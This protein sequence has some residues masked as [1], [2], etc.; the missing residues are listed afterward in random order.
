[1]TQATA[2][3]FAAIEQNFSG[4][5]QCYVLKKVIRSY[6]VEVRLSENV[7]GELL[8]QAV[9]KTLSRLP[10]YRQTIVRQKGIYYYAE[11]DLPFKV[12]DHDGPRPVGGKEANYHM[13][14]VVYHD[15]WLYFSMWHALCDGLGLNRFIE[16]VL[17]H[18]L[19]AKDG[20][21][22]N[23]EDIYTEKVPFDEA[24]LFDPLQTKLKISSSEMKEIQA[25]ASQEG[26][27]R[28]P[29]FDQPNSAGPTMYRLPVKIKTED[30]IAWCKANSSSPAAAA[31]AIMAKAIARVR[32]VS[33]EKVTAVIPCSMR[34][35]MEGAEKT[36][37]NCS[38]VVFINMAPHDVKELPTG[39]LAAQARATLKT[40][41]GSGEA[42]RMYAG[43][44]KLI[45]IGTRLPF[46]GLKCRILAGSENNPQNT[47]YV[48][49]VGGLT[50]HGYEDQIL[51]VR[52]LNADLGCP[53][54]FVLMSE[55][56]GHFH[57]NLTQSFENDEYYHAFCEVL[58]EQNIPFERLP[59]ES[60]MNPAVVV[61]QEQR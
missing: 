43:I 20:I 14:D 28:F 37:K 22:Y 51:E 59:I 34:K 6:V 9:D 16:A 30:F 29:E 15:S 57:I 26:R 53:S 5:T 60:Y 13:V 32:D 58:E 56:A 49:Y 48:D 18:Y 7:S 31:A 46:Y 21:T 23:D 61:P 54:L 27:Y 3:Q 11:N 24:E 39:E 8:Q 50:A 41:M 12:A 19:C 1:M 52:Y 36:F 33:A 25:L 47:F 2:P 38:G 55:T 44:N 35:F 42:N 10:Y 45:H 17:Y 4:T 40:K